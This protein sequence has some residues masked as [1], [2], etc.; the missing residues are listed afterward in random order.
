MLHRIEVEEMK[1]EIAR[2]AATITLGIAAAVFIILGMHADH[3]M[4][5]K[6]CGAIVSLA[7]GLYSKHGAVKLMG[8]PSAAV[9]ARAELAAARDV[10][11]K[12]QAWLQAIA[13]LPSSADRNGMEIRLSNTLRTIRERSEAG[14][15]AA[16]T[17]KDQVLREVWLMAACDLDE[18]GR[19]AH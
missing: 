5:V 19:T 13:E 18:E 7:G 2:A 12:R 8:P 15:F 4:R 3:D 6:V 17:D 9:V 11:L 1:W 16:E 14:L 10:E